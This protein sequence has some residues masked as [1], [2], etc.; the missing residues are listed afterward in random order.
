MDVTFYGNGKSHWV[1]RVRKPQCKHKIF[2]AGECQGTEGHD[3]HHWCYRP[4]GS[5]F[6]DMTEEQRKNNKNDDAVCGSIPPDHKNYISPVDKTKDYHL[7]FYEDTVVTDPQEIAR[8]DAGKIGQG[9][10][11]D[12]PCTAE[13][14]EKIFKK[15][16]I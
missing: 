3:G 16:L 4:D 10:G 14:I 12:R 9:E 2:L 13:E 1:K 5:Y 7:K 11:I 15:R 8:L 6:W